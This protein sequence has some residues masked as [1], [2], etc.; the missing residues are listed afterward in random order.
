MGIS[1]FGKFCYLRP[2]GLPASRLGCACSGPADECGRPRNYSVRRIGRTAVE[3][4]DR[5]RRTTT[6]RRVTAPESCRIVVARRHSHS[7]QKSVA[8]PVCTDLP[9]AETA[10]RVLLR[11]RLRRHP[12]KLVRLFAKSVGSGSVRRVGNHKKPVATQ[13]TVRLLSFLPFS[14]FLVL[15]KIADR[16]SEQRRR[17]SEA[18]LEASLLSSRFIAL[19]LP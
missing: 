4:Q 14:S 1:S 17:S 2:F 15:P 3:G 11:R 10:V 16:L 7:T 19:Y 6:D 12:I 9:I 13:T 18:D 5:C 8:T